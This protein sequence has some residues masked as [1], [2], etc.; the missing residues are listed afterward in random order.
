MQYQAYEVTHAAIAPVRA[1]TQ[2][3]RMIAENPAN[4]WSYTALGRSISAACNIFESLTRRY[5]KPEWQVDQVTIDGIPTP[6]KDKVIAKTPFCSLRHFD[7][8]GPARPRNAPPVLIVAPLSGHFATLLRG[9]VQSM[10]QD[11][12]VY[13]TD[14]HDAR[15][16]PLSYGG[17]DLDDY[18]DDI[19]G[20]IRLLGPKLHVVAVCQ[21]SVP[22]LA[23]TALMAMDK[24]PAQPASL[25]LMGGPIDT[26]RN[27]TLVNQHAQSKSIDWFESNVVTR[28]PFPLPGFMRRVYPGFVQLTGFMTMNL[29][30]HIGAH[31]DLF[32]HLVE[33]DCDSA[34]QHRAFYEEYLSV[35]DLPAEFYLSTVRKV[36]Q[37]H[38]LPK[39]CFSHRGRIVD[40]AAIETPWLMTVEGERDDICGL[41]QTEAAHDLCRNIPDNR[42]THYVQPKVGHY[43]VFNGRR[44]Q[45]E[46][47][48][49]V[50]KMIAAAEQA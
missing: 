21:P 16:V 8:A 2:F 15:E 41:G 22:V 23:A 10:L 26:R 24:D 20:F 14:W 28:V 31:I 42:K 9:T 17:Y 4:P 11:H 37:E 36:F 3:T 46:I 19:M 48:P 47:Y 35:M 43:G 40:C 33:G 29:D 13:V 45:T 34:E 27:P 18:V 49:Q 44:W 38:A 1:S 39:G 32:N 6:I 50:R 30:R 7:T 12:D 5:G 25:T